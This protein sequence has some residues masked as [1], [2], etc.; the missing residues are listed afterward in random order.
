MLDIQIRRFRDRA[1]LTQQELA[2]RCG[3]SRQTINALEAGRYVPGTMLALQLARALRCRVEELFSLDDADEA[4]E[5]VSLARTARTESPSIPAAGPAWLARVGDRWI[6][7]RLAPDASHPGNARILPALEAASPDRAR[8]VPLVPRELLAHTLLVAGCAPAL[9]VLSQRVVE[10]SPGSFLPWIEATSTRALELLA[11]G[12]V[13]VAGMHL[14]D[15]PTGEFNRPI[16]ARRFPG[17]R[18]LC[19]TLAR[20]EQGIVLRSADRVRLR[21]VEDLLRPGLRLARREPGAGAEKLLVRLL[22]RLG[23]ELPPPRTPYAS[24]HLEVA[25]QVANGSADAGIAVRAVALA[26]G[27]EFVPL[28]E[29]RFDLVLHAELAE[30]SRVQRLLDLLAG[31]AFRRELAAL[32]GYDAAHTGEVCVVEAAA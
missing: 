8:V 7:H 31:S 12:F 3:V 24:G 18:M 32:G 20:W 14:L 17:R 19:S 9:G 21:S 13:H 23:G 1:G 11:A 22:G 26:F 16:V 28:A 29:E 10:R 2:R 25:R 5:E 6:A 27:L 30:D 4:L 15:E